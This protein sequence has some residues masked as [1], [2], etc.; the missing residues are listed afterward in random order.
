MDGQVTYEI[1]DRL[2]IFFF[3]GDEAWYATADFLLRVSPA[4]YL[5]VHWPFMSGDATAA[6]LTKEQFYAALCV[7][8]DQLLENS[9]C[10]G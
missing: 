1:R 8:H 5:S 4:D 7:A 10:T 3:N 9:C 6:G 2:V